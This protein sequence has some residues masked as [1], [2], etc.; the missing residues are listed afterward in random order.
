QPIRP[1]ARDNAWPKRVAWHRR[2][3]AFQ[4]GFLIESI[5]DLAPLRDPDA[6][7]ARAAAVSACGRHPVRISL[8]GSTINSPL[9]WSQLRE[10]PSIASATRRSPG[11]TVMSPGALRRPDRNEVTSSGS[12]TGVGSA[13]T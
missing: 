7:A 4:G 8:P 11:G 12:D 5:H 9:S 2:G 1:L 6:I 3:F 10:R 13:T